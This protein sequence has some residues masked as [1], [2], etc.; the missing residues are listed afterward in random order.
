[1]LFHV[2][3][4]MLESDKVAEICASIEKVFPETPYMGCSTSG[5]I[6]DCELSTQIMVACTV[7]ELPSTKVPL[8]SRFAAFISAAFTAD[9]IRQCFDFYFSTQP[10]AVTRRPRDYFFP[11]SY[12][13]RMLG[14]VFSSFEKRISG[15]EAQASLH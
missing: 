9:L 14:F 2:Y 4:E 1:M 6:A 10:S 8:V 3:T 5:N 11:I 7:F 13:F 12:H 15:N